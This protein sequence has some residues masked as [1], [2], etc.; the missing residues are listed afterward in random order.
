MRAMANWCVKHRRT[1]VASW[2]LA[3][4]GVTAL[5]AAHGSAYENSFSLKGTQSYEAQQLLEQAAPT[6]SG[7]RDQVVIAVNRG[8][9]T[10]AVVKRR[11]ERMLNQVAS[12]PDVASILSPYTAA[13]A[14]QISKS[15]KVVFATVTMTKLAP[16]FTVSQAKQFVNTARAGAGDGLEVAVNGQV[17]EQSEPPSLGGAGLGALA[18]LIVLLIVFGS[19]F[20]AVLPLLTAGIGL[21]IGVSVVGLLSH[22]ITMADLQRAAVN[23]DRA[24]RR[25]RLRALHRH[26]PPP[27]TATGQIRRGGGG[28]RGR[29]LWACGD[30]RRYHGLHRPAR[31]VC[32][33]G[34]PA[35][36]NRDR[37]RRGRRIHRPGR[38]DIAPRAARFHGRARA[39]QTGAT[40]TLRRPTS[41]QR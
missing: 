5:L 1:V 19:L 11:A 16:S 41:A 3:L 33:W 30:V 40:P 36:R 4:I 23:P 31:D 25:R 8:T 9:V 2:L 24:R 22:V 15:G 39:R 12:L 18:A 7:D 38:A 14:G 35:R 10:D 26:P 21:G 29:Y 20:A 6:A 34:E 27:G 28:R 17:A 13:G 37:S 32:A